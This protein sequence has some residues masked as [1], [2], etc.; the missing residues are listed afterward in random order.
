MTCTMQLFCKVEGMT[1]LRACQWLDSRPT[2]RLAGARVAGMCRAEVKAC[3]CR[4]NVPLVL[5]WPL[6]CC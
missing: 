6:A 5:C 2:V 3:A 4:F 1:G